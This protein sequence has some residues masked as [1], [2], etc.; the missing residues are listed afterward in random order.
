MGFLRR[1]WKDPVWSKVISAVILLALA[2]GAHLAGIT[3]DGVWAAALSSARYFVEPVA[4]ARWLLWLWI[5]FTAAVFSIVALRIYIFATEKPVQAPPPKRT[6]SLPHQAYVTDMFFK[7]RWRWK[8][9]ASGEVWDISMY[10]PACDQ[11]LVTSD[12]ETYRY[13]EFHCVC[14]HCKYTA[15]V[16]GS[17]PFDMENKIKLAAERKIRTGEWEKAGKARKPAMRRA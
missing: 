1:I 14:S 15:E 7:F 6:A 2:Y 9:A 17:S 10:C 8:T 11:Q 5:M 4:L 3:L 13:R 16:D 12:F